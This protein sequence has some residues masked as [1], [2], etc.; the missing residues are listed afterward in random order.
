MTEEDG[1]FKP[2]SETT[3][4]IVGLGLIGGSLAMALHGSCK[5]LIGCDIDQATIHRVREM[6]I[7]DEA[8][9]KAENVLPEAELI[10]LATPVRTILQILY[11]LP[12]LHPGNA[13]ILDT[14]ST[15]AQI[16]H[17]LNQLPERFDPIGGHPI[18]GKEKGTLEA[19]E[20]TLFKNAAFVLTPLARTTT[21]AIRMAQQLLRIIGA[22][23]IWMSA[24]THDTWT[25][26]TSHMPYLISNALAAATPSEAAIL[27]GPGF[28]SMTRIAA[29]PSSIMLDILLTNKQNILQALAHFR[30]QL[31]VLETLLQTENADGLNQKLLSGA[32]HQKELLQYT[33]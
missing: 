13:M 29:T 25:A 11:Q 15:K 31:D 21:R 8:D 7:V 5:K 17:A 32:N 33:T 1:F 18:C 24:E 30:S 9:T 26:A 14:G 22:Q 23:D 16:V 27:I 2:I 3:I 10:I 28:R 4:A 19:A 12:S 6:R 20:A